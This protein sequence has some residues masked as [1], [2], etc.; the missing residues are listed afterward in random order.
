M[1]KIVNLQASYG[2]SLILQG[3]DL[4]VPKGHIVALMGR[5]GVG[6]TT[7]LKSIVGLMPPS[8]GQVFLDGKNIAGLPPYTI[9]ALG[10]GY[11]PQ[12]K[13]IFQNF[14]IY[15]NLRLGVVKRKR[16]G[17]VIPEEVFEYFPIL[18]ER[19]F[20]KAGS[21]SGGE[22]QM[23]AIGRA[24]ASNPKILFLDEPSEGIAP[25]VVDEIGKILVRINSEKKVTVLIVEQN[26]DLV[27]GMAQ[28]CFFMEKGR[29]TDSSE[30]ELLK[31]DDKLITR[32]LAL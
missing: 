18:K 26:V 9:S 5:N 24:L 22:Q 13:G 2:G 30:A 28:E 32:Y 4:E 12:G 20:Q 31:K 7:L 11:V 21:F 25:K 16:K 1:L 27:L 23:L 19:Q 10:I 6:K 8:A 29:I 17:R 15:E 14:T 3:V